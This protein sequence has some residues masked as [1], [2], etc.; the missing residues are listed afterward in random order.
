MRI[1]I[2][3]DAVHVAKLLAESIRLQ[4]HEAIVARSGWEGLA[5]LQQ[6]PPDAVFLDI[7]MPGVSG[8]D[9][10]RH[11]RE[12]HPT[13]PVIVITGSASLEDIDEV[14]RLGVTEIIEKP[15]ALK[16]LDDALG[17]LQAEKS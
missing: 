7:V 6:K 15:F 13:L 2:V 12:T 16:Q 14:R 3:E 9:V 8:L 17:N 11:I 5:L 4:G 10:L 1:L